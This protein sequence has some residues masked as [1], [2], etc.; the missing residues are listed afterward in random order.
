[1]DAAEFKMTVLPMSRKLLH[2]AFQI[3]HDSAEA[4][5]TIQEVVLKLWNIRHSLKSIK[6]PE[7]FAMT[8]TRNWCLD[9]LK[10]KKPVYI[11]TYHFGYD[12]QSDEYDP[13]RQV[14]HEDRLNILYRVI[15]NLPEQQKQVVQLRDI[16]GLEYEQIAEIMDMNLNALRVTLSRARNKIRDELIKFDAYGYQ[17]NKNTAGKLL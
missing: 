16:E 12:R 17:T 9:R 15:D 2:Y 14:E 6:N 3:L 1:M 7:A 13:H 11:A 10:A 8:I 5:D 4:E